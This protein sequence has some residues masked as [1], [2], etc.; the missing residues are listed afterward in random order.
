M[1]NQK[2]I[3]DALNKRM[4]IGITEDIEKCEAEIYFVKDSTKTDVYEKQPD[5]SFRYREDL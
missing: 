2:T 5:G 3:R 4:K 1:P